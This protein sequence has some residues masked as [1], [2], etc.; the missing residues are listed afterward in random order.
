LNAS[1]GFNATGWRGV[2]LWLNST[3]LQKYAASLAPAITATGF[4]TTQ[5]VSYGPILLAVNDVIKIQITQSSGSNLTYEAE[6]FAG[7]ISPCQ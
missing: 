5:T 7:M 2:K 3:D 6:F 1:W 4:Y